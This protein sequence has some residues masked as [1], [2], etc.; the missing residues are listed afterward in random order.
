MWWVDHN[1]KFRLNLA[2]DLSYWSIDCMSSSAVFLQ[3]SKEV[4][5]AAKILSLQTF[6]THRRQRCCEQNVSALI[7]NPQKNWFSHSMRTEIFLATK[8]HLINT[9]LKSSCLPV[10]C[11]WKC[12]AFLMLASFIFCAFVCAFLEYDVHRRRAILRNLVVIFVAGFQ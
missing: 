5:A 11:T 12:F 3:N 2:R 4:T 7:H 8:S 6:A 10:V 9:N 1:R